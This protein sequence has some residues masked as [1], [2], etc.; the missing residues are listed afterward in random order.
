MASPYDHIPDDVKKQAAAENNQTPPPADRSSPQ[1]IGEQSQRAGP[2]MDLGV[3]LDPLANGKPFR[4]QRRILKRTR[5]GVI[6]SRDEVKAIK[7][8]RK[9]LRKE[10]KSRGIKGKEDFEM[11]AASLGLY[12]DKR[13]GL[14]FWLWGHWLGL[15]IGSGLALLGVLFVFSLV[16][17]MRGHFTINLSDDM[18]K[19]GFVLS[20][21]VEFMNSTTKLFAIPAE[22]VPCISIS[23]ITPEVDMID[24][25]HSENYFAYTYYV[26]NEGENSVGYVW[27][28]DINQE[29]QNLSDA[30]WVILFED[31]EMRFYAKANNE[32]GDS[33][34]LPSFYDS[35]MGYMNIPLMEAAPYSDQFEVVDHVGRFTYYR[36]VPASFISDKVIATGMQEDVD[37]MEVHKYTV[38]L[39]LEGDDPECTDEL[40]GGTMG[41]EMNYR[42]VR[43][44]VEEDT[45]FIGRWKRFWE[46][47]WDK[48][49]FWNDN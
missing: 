36:V 32:T 15:L 43:E 28:L 7:K 21:N 14:F 29:T 17:Q 33:E 47:A 3:D 23:Q 25:D 11:I 38:V 20:D 35:S 10:M 12:F 37:P 44:E 8:G 9:K 39:Y 24:G 27:E 1:S 42:L 5:A 19:E 45:S 13:R 34:A 30:T 49:Q 41:V 18:F 48:M 40:I 26:R 4:K 22:D 46:K 6:L 16:Q 31:G 2:G